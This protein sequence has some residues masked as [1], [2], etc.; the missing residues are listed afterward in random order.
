MKAGGASE[1]NASRILGSGPGFTFVGPNPAWRI[2]YGNDFGSKYQY[3]SGSGSTN[4]P[5]SNLAGP[6]CTP[7]IVGAVLAPS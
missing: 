1:N 6:Y 7:L 3:A 2:V 4:F 5:F